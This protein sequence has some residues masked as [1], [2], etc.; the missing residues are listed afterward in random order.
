MPCIETLLHDLNVR[1][2]LKVILRKQITQEDIELLL[3]R[4]A[5]A[6]NLTLENPKWLVTIKGRAPDEIFV[7]CRETSG[8]YA[9]AL[10]IKIKEIF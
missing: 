9:E 2:R 8:K 10:R 4:P 1:Y 7:M 5:A 6:I 3:T